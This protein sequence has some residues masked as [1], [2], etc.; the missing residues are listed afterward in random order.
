MGLF[1]VKKIFGDINVS[2]L[3]RNVRE[4]Y[5]PIEYMLYARFE[6]SVRGNGKT[7]LYQHNQIFLLAYNF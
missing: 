3:Q 7:G 1:N 5:A 6:K 4:A 2:P